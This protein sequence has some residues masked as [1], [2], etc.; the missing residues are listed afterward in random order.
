MKRFL[1]HTGDRIMFFVLIG[2][3]ALTLILSALRQFGHLALI[4]GELYLYL[5]LAIV[6]GTLGWG[7]SAIHRLLKKPLARGIVGAAMVLVMLVLAT[8]ALSYAGVAAGFSFPARYVTVKSPGGAHKLTVMRGLDMD[9]E[10]INA[11]HEAR[12]AADPDGAQDVTAEDWGY[13]FTAYSTDPFGLFYKE[14]TLL[15]GKVCIG[16]ASKAELMVD[17]EEDETVGHFYVK[18]PEI[19]DGGEMRAVSR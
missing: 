12:L 16:Y 4:H 10:H 15:E 14:D 9:E 8:I 7:M 5:P 11:R 17:W 3:V 19:A 6:L 2:L 18:N 1:S 13:V